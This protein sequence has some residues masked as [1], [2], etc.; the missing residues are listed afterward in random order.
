[1]IFLESSSE[2]R[3]NKY[4]KKYFRILEVSYKIISST[5]NETK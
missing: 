5:K 3:P 2:K 4:V 1:M